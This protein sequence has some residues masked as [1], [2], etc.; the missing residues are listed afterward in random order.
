MSFR[1]LDIDDK[2]CRFWRAWHLDIDDESDLK[3]DEPKT[4]IVMTKV[5]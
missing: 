1:H 2:S 5:M 3:F 4:S